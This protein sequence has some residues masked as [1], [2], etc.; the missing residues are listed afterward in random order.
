MLER[1]PGVNERVER[2]KAQLAKGRKVEFEPDDR[3]G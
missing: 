2:G 3:P 1:T